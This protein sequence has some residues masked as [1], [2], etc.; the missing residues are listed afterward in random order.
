MNIIFVIIVIILRLF[1]FI[2][3]VVTIWTIKITEHRHI[4]PVYI[5]VI[6]IV[7][8]CYYRQFVFIDIMMMTY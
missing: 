7:C 4:L 8:Y 3:G 1:E 5:V 2:Y 6:V